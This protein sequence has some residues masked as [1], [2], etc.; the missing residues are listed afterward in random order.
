MWEGWWW[1]GGPLCVLIVVSKL[2]SLLT[3]KQAF[4][5]VTVIDG[6][7]TADGLPIAQSVLA[8]P[9]KYVCSSINRSVAGH[10]GKEYDKERIES[11]GGL[12]K[13]VMK[14]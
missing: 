7:L 8:W 4:E 6:F 1:C 9:L 12:G 13:R 10:T 14:G 3:R 5:F 11:A 2:P